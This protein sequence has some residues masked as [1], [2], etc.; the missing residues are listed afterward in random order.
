MHRR[1][2]MS[3]SHAYSLLAEEAWT[4]SALAYLREVDAIVTRRHELGSGSGSNGAGRGRGHGGAQP[5]AGA[6][7][8]LEPAAQEA[9]TGDGNPAGRRG[10]RLKN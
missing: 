4:T 6:D 7:P 10:R 2:D 3:V 5:L 9:D 1:P 8:V